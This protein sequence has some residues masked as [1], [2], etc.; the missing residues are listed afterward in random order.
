MIYRIIYKLYVAASGLFGKLA[1]YQPVVILIL[2][3][4]RYLTD[5]VLK[6]TANYAKGE[7]DLS[8][9]FAVNCRVACIHVLFMVILVGSSASTIT[10]CLLCVVDAVLNLKLCYSI[11]KIKR[12]LLDDASFKSK[13]QLQLLSLKESLEIL[14]PTLYCPILCLGFFGPN[15]QVLG[16]IQTTSWTDDDLHDLKN[17]F[18]KLGMFM[19]FDISRIFLNSYILWKF[20]KVSLYSEFCQMMAVYWK[21]ITTCV[22]IFVLVVSCTLFS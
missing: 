14:V 1:E 15:A 9:R 21:L 2:P 5:K 11:I 7:D 10:A 6:T 12:S 13:D 8:A 22:A 4:M 3:L 20:C 16:F 17:S 18:A 19:I